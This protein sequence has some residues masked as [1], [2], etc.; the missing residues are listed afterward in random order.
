MWT[1]QPRDNI[2]YAQ[3]Y[4]LQKKLSPKEDPLC[5]TPVGYSGILK[6]QKSQ[7]RTLSMETIGEKQILRQVA[8][9]GPRLDEVSKALSTL[10]EK[11]WQSHEV[12]SD[13]K[14]ENTAP[15]LGK[16]KR[17]DPGNCRP[18]SLTSVPIKITEQILLETVL[19]HTE[20]KGVIGD[21]QHGL[22]KGK[23]H[24]TNLVAFYE[25]AT[26]VVDE[27]RATDVI[28]RDL[29]KTSDAV[30]HNILVS[31]LERHGF[32]RRITSGK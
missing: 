31:K 27:G 3:D 19:G 13:G 18:V 28:Y 30:P 20:N 23:S 9:V 32:Y 12:P 2:H 15:S 16:G 7:T 29:R 6:T 8:S 11:S 1:V 4:N 21:S 17:N 22:T 24:M 5:A 26:V 10:F 25:E 14:R